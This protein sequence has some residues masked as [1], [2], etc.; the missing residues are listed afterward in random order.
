MI[1]ETNDELFMTMSANTIWYKEQWNKLGKPE[2]ICW[3]S[4]L[5]REKIIQK[6]LFQ[7]S[8]SFF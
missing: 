7:A 3:N 6:S 8:Y 4:S 5:N 1:T 2:I